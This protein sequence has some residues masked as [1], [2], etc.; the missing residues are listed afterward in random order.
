MLAQVLVPVL[1]LL[2]VQLVFQQLQSQRFGFS[3]QRLDLEPAA[4]TTLVCQCDAT[5]YLRVLAKYGANPFWVIA[6]LASVQQHDVLRSSS[7]AARDDLANRL[8]G[9]G[10]REMTKPTGDATLHE[11]RTWASP[12]QFRIVVAFDRQD[13]DTGELFNQIARHMSKIGGVADSAAGRLNGE[14]AGSLVIVRQGNR[15][16]DQMR[17]RLKRLAVKGA[18]E[19]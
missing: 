18:D 3:L 19:P 13:V 2:Q 10:V 9:F 16:D 12:L 8:V 7:R 5:A 6:L 14:S 11:R 15:L 17:N 1:L 4:P